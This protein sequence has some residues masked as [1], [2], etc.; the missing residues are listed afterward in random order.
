[1][2]ERESITAYAHSIKKLKKECSDKGLSEDEFRKL[3]FESLNTI[4]EGDNKLSNISRSFV[5]KRKFLLILLLI[6]TIYSIKYICCN[7]L[8]NLQELIYPGLRLIRQISIP[9]I[10]LFP[11]LTELY[12]EPCLIQNPF[13]TIIDMDCWPCSTVTNVHQIYDPQP[14]HQQHAAPFIYETDQEQVDTKKLRNLYF[15]N[16]ELFDKES[17]KI[18]MNNKFHLAP[19]NVFQNQQDIED[20]NLYVWKINNLNL[21]R[22]LRQL[23]PRAKVVP[24]FG[25][26]TERFIIIDS[27]HSDFN[28]PDTEC[29]FA[30]LLVLS[31]TRTVTLYPAEECKHQCKSIEVDLKESYL[32]WYNWWYWRPVV[33]QSNGN[34]TFVAHVGSYC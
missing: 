31:G 33:Q 11:A 16:K 6:L 3:Y 1:M 24:K 23:I 21:A 12:Q 29:N 2:N 34:S 5:T 9:F 22:I 4:E 7:V 15:R 26:S 13:Y 17:S 19:S 28:I 27:S 25:Q 20:R 8:C 10:S 30:F 18:V 14:L 32:L